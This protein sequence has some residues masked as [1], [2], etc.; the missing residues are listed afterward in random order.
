MHQRPDVLPRNSD[1]SGQTA[2]PCHYVELRALRRAEI[3]DVVHEI[4]MAFGGEAVPH[5]SGSVVV[6]EWD[7]VPQ[8][9]RSNDRH[10]EAPAVVGHELGLSFVHEA[11]EVSE[12]SGLVLVLANDAESAH[13]VVAVE[14]KNPDDDDLMMR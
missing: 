1:L 4:E 11:G 7:P 14:P 5:L 10:V 3:G 2:E 12:G 9:P 8:A 6:L 13:V